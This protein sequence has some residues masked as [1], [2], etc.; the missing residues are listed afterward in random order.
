MKD[1]RFYFGHSYEVITAET[2]RNAVLKFRQMF[3]LS[4]WTI[5]YALPKEHTFVC[6]RDYRI[7]DDDKVLFYDCS[8]IPVY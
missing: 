2:A 1:Y 3:N 4:Y 8:V 5:W 7:S 6:V